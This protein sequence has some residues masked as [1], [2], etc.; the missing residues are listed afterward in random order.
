[1]QKMGVTAVMLSSVMLSSVRDEK[2]APIAFLAADADL[3]V[4]SDPLAPARE[5][6]QLSEG[7]HKAGIELWMQVPSV[8]NHFYFLPPLFVPHPKR[9]PA[10]VCSIA[11]NL[12]KGWACSGRECTDF[13]AYDMGKVR[14]QH[15]CTYVTL[16]ILY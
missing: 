6:C 11:E 5:L 10:C 7:L 13:A 3:A 2:R 9:I 14:T 12:A 4:E 8:P 15:F 1:M 16:K